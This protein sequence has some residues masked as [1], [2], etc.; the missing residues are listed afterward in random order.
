MIRRGGSSE[1]LPRTEVVSRVWGHLL[2]KKLQDSADKR[3]IVP[4]EKLGAVFGK[5]HSTMFGMKKSS[6]LT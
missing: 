1:P 3:T 4:G 6:V 5:D 2:A